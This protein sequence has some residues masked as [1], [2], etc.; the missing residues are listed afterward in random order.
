MTTAAMS[1]PSDDLRATAAHLRQVAEAIAREAGEPLKTVF[2]AGMEVDYKTD[3]HDPVTIHDKRTE[4]LIRAR[5]LKAVPG[6]AIVGE[7]GGESGSGEIKWYVDPI[8]GTANFAA[9][10]A[11]WCVSIGAVKGD[12]IIA[13]VVYDPVADHLFSGDLDGAWLN[14]APLTGRAPR[15]EARALVVTGFP[16]QRDFRLD[17]AEVAL[18]DFAQLVSAFSTTRRTGS[19]ALTLCHVAAG[20]I[21]CAMGF[22]VN[23]WDVT[24]SIL[25]LRNAGGTYAPLTQGRQP[26]GAPAHLCPGYY[27]TSA[28]GDFPTLVRVATAIDGRRRLQHAAAK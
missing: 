12:E 11:F 25:I 14:G 19:A 13:G 21:D 27:A 15:E 5:L 10:L 16:V 26:D 9:G 22:G 4:E 17:G 28:G 20:W 7:E 8:D 1:R 23:A 3:L 6:A 2:R 24:A 18:A